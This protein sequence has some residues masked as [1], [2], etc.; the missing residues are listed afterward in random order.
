MA[1]GCCTATLAVAQGREVFRVIEV[2]PDGTLA[3]RENVA[4]VS[5][6]PPGTLRW[7]DVAGEGDSLDRLRSEFA[8]HPLAIEDCRQF[9]QRPKLEE[10]RDHLFLVT[11]GF[12]V[13]RASSVRAKPSRGARALRGETRGPQSKRCRASS[14][15][16]CTCTSCTP[17]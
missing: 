8:F 2:G 16:A 17:F 5:L 1:A 4:D 6:P 12:S 9:N 3:V 13:I 7:V 11:Q 14:S 15:S 10:Y